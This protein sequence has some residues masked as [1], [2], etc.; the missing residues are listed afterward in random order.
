MTTILN[1]A[2]FLNLRIFTAP[3]PKSTASQQQLPFVRWRQVDFL[4][5]HRRLLLGLSAPRSRLASICFWLEADQ[6]R[7]RLQSLQEL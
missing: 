1:Q 6:A 3:K 4:P 7:A 5:I 2:A